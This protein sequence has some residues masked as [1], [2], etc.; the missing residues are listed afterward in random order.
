MTSLMI[1]NYLC[2][3]IKNLEL[4]G[5]CVQ[6]LLCFDGMIHFPTIHSYTAT[7]LNSKEVTVQPNV[8]PFPKCVT[9]NKYTSKFTFV[10]SFQIHYYDMEKKGGETLL[11]YEEKRL[12]LSRYVT[13]CN[14]HNVIESKY[15]VKTN[16][17]FSS[18]NMQ[19]HIHTSKI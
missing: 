14:V 6:A 13:D 1:G 15:H 8:Y 16:S 9:S 4:Q 10:T 3:S 5:L 7:V 19:N 12:S 11:V 17:G 2:P 18:V